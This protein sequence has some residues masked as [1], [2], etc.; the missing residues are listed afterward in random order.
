M[1]WITLLFVLVFETILCMAHSDN[2]IESDLFGNLGERDKAAILVVHFGTTHDDTRALTIDVINAK[3]KEAFPGIEA[4]EAWTSRIILRTLKERGVGRQNPTQALIQL[5]EQ[6]YTHILIQSTN[7][8]EGTEMKELRREVEG[9]SLNFKD[10]RV[11]NPLLYAPEDYEVVVK[12]VTE[13]MNQAN[14]GGQ[15]LLVGHGTPDPATASYAM[16]DYML[17]AEGHPEYHV[18]T[19]EGYPEYEDALRLLKN[20][21]SK[22]LTL[23]PLMF[24]VGDHA[25]NDIAGEWK[26]NLEKQ[27]YK[28]NLYLKGLGEN[29]TVQQLFIQHARFAAGHKAV[30]MATKK[31]GYMQGK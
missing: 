14:K 13:A 15:K 5:H 29:P 7:I 10:I 30:D 22:T 20:G 24:V 9:L 2:F 4:R 1:K 11:G 31:K 16:F 19:V 21:K 28:V 3:M 27:G 18:G 6:G 25:K 8:I 26:E 23:A 17:K 12:A